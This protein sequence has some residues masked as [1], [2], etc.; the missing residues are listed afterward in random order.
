ME[1]VFGSGVIDAALSVCVNSV[2]YFQQ[3]S[4]QCTAAEYVHPFVCVITASHLRDEIDNI[5]Q[6]FTVSLERKPMFQRMFQHHDLVCNRLVVVCSSI[7][8]L[9]RNQQLCLDMHLPIFDRHLNVGCIADAQPRFYNQLRAVLLHVYKL[10]GDS[11]RNDG[12]ASAQQVLNKCWRRVEQVVIQ[13]PAKSGCQCLPNQVLR[14]V[15]LANE[16]RCEARRYAV[17]EHCAS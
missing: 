7:A 12:G 1:E 6:C 15:T 2:V 8:S 3:R 9:V 16:F 4:A 17:V 5:D 14:D 10:L 11:V 13:V